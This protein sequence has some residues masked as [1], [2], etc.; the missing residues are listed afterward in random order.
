MAKRIENQRRYGM[1][2]EERNTESVESKKETADETVIEPEAQEEENQ[3]K[4]TGETAQNSKE[5]KKTPDGPNEPEKENDGLLKKVKEILGKGKDSQTENNKTFE[6]YRK[7]DNVLDECLEKLEKILEKD[8]LIFRMIK[9]DLAFSWREKEKHKKEYFS[10][11]NIW[12][13]FIAEGMSKI[14]SSVLSLSIA[15]TAFDLFKNKTI[16]IK[17]KLIA[18]AVAMVL[19]VLSAYTIGKYKSYNRNEDGETWVRHSVY[20]NKMRYLIIK[21]IEKNDQSHGS[22]QKFKKEVF[23]LANENLDQFKS[24]MMT[25]K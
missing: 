2:E 17:W 20:F 24:N 23:E 1:S 12:L 16:D 3:E 13:E 19:L 9:Q 22:I 11:K 7:E 25:Q 4:T 8:N 14:A 10:K 18:T 15:A 6:Q 21:F 5:E